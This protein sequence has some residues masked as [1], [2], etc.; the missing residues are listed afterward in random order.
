V[1][2]S[3]DIPLNV[4]RSFLQADGNVKK[5][6]SYITK[7]VAEKLADMFKNDRKGF[8]EKWKDIG[9]FIKY[10][11][12][13]E[14]KFNDKA[15]DFALLQNVKNEYYTLPEYAE[16][17]SP[18]QTDKNGEVVYLYS[19]NPAAQNTF[20]QAAAKKDYD[21][22]LMDGPLDNHFIGQLEQKLE[23]T[24]MKR[25]DAD[26]MDKLIEKEHNYESVLNEDQTQS[27][28]A[29]FEKTINNQHMNVEVTAMSPEDLPVTITM[30]E[31]MRRMKDMSK[32]GGGMMNFYGNLPDSYKVSVNGNSKLI[33]KIVD[34]QDE[35]QKEQLSRQAFDLALLA[36][37]MLTGDALTAFVQRSVNLM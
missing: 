10:G 30:D 1:I 28:K 22:L 2:D 4:S 8:E 6:N 9:L 34:T 31:F 37:G 35:A 16:K 29:L 36:Q 20:I 27:V 7:K 14:E 33:Q 32:M 3:P 24:R 18:L 12:I 23:K 15:K 5:I 25:V 11:M 19:A 21:V 26:V 13:S 17:V